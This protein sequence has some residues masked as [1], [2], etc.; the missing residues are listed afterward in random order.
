MVKMPHLK[1]FGIVPD[2]RCKMN[3]SDNVEYVFQFTIIKRLEYGITFNNNA[4]NI[5]VLSF[6]SFLP[7]DWIW[8][9]TKSDKS[10]KLNTRF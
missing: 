8:L 4:Q 3:F 2:S 6:V 10:R 7:L 1:K 9:R 5:T